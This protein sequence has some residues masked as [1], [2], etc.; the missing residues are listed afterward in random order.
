MK[1]PANLHFT[2]CNRRNSGSAL[3]RS[4]QLSSS[5]LVAGLARPQLGGIDFQL[6]TEPRPA[7]DAEPRL[8]RSVLLSVLERRPHEQATD[9]NGGQDDEEGEDDLSAGVPATRVVP[10]KADP[11]PLPAR[12]PC[13]ASNTERQ[14]SSLVQGGTGWSFGHHDYKYESANFQALPSLPAFLE[15]AQSNLRSTPVS[16][17]HRLCSGADHS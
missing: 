9:E 15:V 4:E 12:R 3:C 6:A 10:A 2:A 11:T 1:V 13:R 7:T 8:Q 14:T 17:H 16:P 5:V